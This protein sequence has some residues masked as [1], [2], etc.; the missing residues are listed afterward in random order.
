M[1]CGL[2]AKLCCDQDLVSAVAKC[3]YG[4]KERFI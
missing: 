3:V 2:S 1:I 4:N